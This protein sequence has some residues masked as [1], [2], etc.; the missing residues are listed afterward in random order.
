MRFF[1]VVLLILLS[2]QFMNR[3]EAFASG[4]DEYYKPITGDFLNITWPGCNVEIDFGPLGIISCPVS[5]D[6]SDDLYALRDILRDNHKITMTLYYNSKEGPFLVDNKVMLKVPVLGFIKIHP[7]D[8]SEN[9]CFSAPGGETT[10]GMFN[11]R[12]KVLAAWDVELNRVYRNLGGSKNPELKAAQLAWIKYRDARFKWIDAE[13][14]KRQ[15][16]KWINKI[17]TRKIEIVRNQVE[18]LQSFYQGW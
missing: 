2:L 12:R 9:N 15:D 10:M 17:M 16:S 1:L 14:G 3:E 18:R 11:C 8:I 4:I 13:F 5:E 6:Y 7:I